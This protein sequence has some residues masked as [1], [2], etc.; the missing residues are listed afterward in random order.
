[1]QWFQSREEGSQAAW[2]CWFYSHH[3]YWRATTFPCVTPDF[4]QHNTSTRS[5][6]SDCRYARLSPCTTDSTT[7]AHYRIDIMLI[8]LNLPA[9]H[10]LVCEAL[11]PMF[12]MCGKLLWSTISIL[13]VVR[14]CPRPCV[15]AKPRAAAKPP[16]EPRPAACRGQ[17]GEPRHV[18]ALYNLV[19][20]DKLS[21]LGDL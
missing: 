9:T 10:T 19:N 8:K 1:M 13:I 14:T 15:A 6:S 11:L 16:C 18:A 17:R 3:S 21:F 12:L 2:Y 5:C 20:T 7:I 4:R